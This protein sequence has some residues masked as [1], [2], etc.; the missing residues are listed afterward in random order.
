MKRQHWMARGLVAVASL[1]GLI[2]AGGASV[3]WR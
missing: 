2:L 3:N 1:L